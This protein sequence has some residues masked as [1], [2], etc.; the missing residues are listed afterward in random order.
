MAI[1][2]AVIVGC[3]TCEV[4]GVPDEST[5]PKGWINFSHR[6][7]EV[8]VRTYYFCSL[9]C[10]QRRLESVIEV[11]KTKL[12]R[13]SGAALP[14]PIEADGW[15]EEWAEKIDAKAREIAEQRMYRS[16]AMAEGG[17]GAG[18]GPVVPS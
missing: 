2:T 5:I 10:M 14:G 12:R 6:D 3:D 8:G 7:L 11:R 18:L 4:E 16:G 9:E 15:P 17:A 1:R 13:S